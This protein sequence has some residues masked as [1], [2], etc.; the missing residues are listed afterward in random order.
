MK[1]AKLNW[2]RLPIGEIENCR[3]LGGYNTAYGQQTKWHAFLRSSELSKLTTEDIAFLKEYG[4]NTVIDLRR[5]DEIEQFYNPLADLNSFTYH[6]IS[7]ITERAS[8]ITRY[9]DNAD[10]FTMG[11]FYI[12]LLK[13]HNTVKALFETIA[14]AEEG[15]VLFHC[16]VGKDRTGV[17][18]M[19]LLWLAGVVKKDIVSNYEV[20]FSNLE[21]LHELKL[22]VDNPRF[23]ISDRED[24]LKAY[25]Y[26][27]ENFGDAENYL[28]HIGLTEETVELVKE[29]FIEDYQDV[30]VA[31]AIED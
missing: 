29:R 21:S 8:D 1:N 23:L 16:Q 3:D 6:N 11:D 30:P 9:R 25:D 7:F 13:Q 17:L 31:A 24:I 5:K 10:F 4:V 12:E 15:C 14:S 2:V 27:Y 26:V 22:K 18:A 20:S 19:L 28:K